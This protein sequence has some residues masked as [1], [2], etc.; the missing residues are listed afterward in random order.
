MEEGHD[1]NSK[2]LAQLGALRCLSSIFRG[3]DHI[4]RPLGE[5]LDNITNTIY[6]AQGALYNISSYKDSQRKYYSI[7][8]SYKY[9]KKLK[10][11][12]D[13]LF[14]YFGTLALDWLLSP[15]DHKVLYTGG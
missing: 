6:N 7:R 1:R 8:L 4:R 14:H 9:V 5:A 13:Q 15:V 12:K 2:I 10:I 3:G 11:T